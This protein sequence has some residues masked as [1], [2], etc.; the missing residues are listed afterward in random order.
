LFRGAA[1]IVGSPLAGA[2]YDATKSYDIPFF[3]AAGF[4]AISTITSFLAPTL[5]RCTKPN[6]VPVHME[7]LTPIDEEPAEDNDEDQ[8]IT[9]IPK[10]MHTAPSPTAEIPAPSNVTSTTTINNEQTP[11]HQSSNADVGAQVTTPKATENSTEKADDKRESQN[12]QQTIPSV[13]VTNGSIDK[14]ISQIESVL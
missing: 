9:M 2:V 8:P 6:E 7:T 13:T 11:K 5:K 10:I 14:E 4:F 12:K 1:A 3:M